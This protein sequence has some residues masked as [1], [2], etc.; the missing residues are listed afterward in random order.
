MK[1]VT[2]AIAVAL[3]LLAGCAAYN[4]RDVDV[5]NVEPVCAGDCK[6]SYSQCLP[7]VDSKVSIT[8]ALT[9]CKGEYEQCIKTCP[10]KP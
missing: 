4:I 1:L 10:A 6:T 2:F 8:E 7:D 3:I 5:S 9:V